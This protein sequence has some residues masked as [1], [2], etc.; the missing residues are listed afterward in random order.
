MVMMSSLEVYEKLRGELNQI[1]REGDNLVE[2]DELWLELISDSME[3]KKVLEIARD[4]KEEGNSLFK[5]GKVD[6][7]LEMYGYAEVILARY[8]FEEEEDRSKFCELALCILLNSTACF[9]RKK[10]FVQ[11]GQVC[12]IILEFQPNNVKAMYR[13]AMA[14]IELERHDM[15]YWDLVLAAEINPKNQEVVKK[16]EEV[17]NFIKAK[18]STDQH[19]NDFPKGLGSALPPPMKK[20]EHN[21]EIEHSSL[22]D[23]YQEKNSTI[24]VGKED[25]GQHIV[26]MS[27]VD[28]KGS[29]E[30]PIKEIEEGPKMN[31]EINP[32]VRMEGRKTETK[33]EEMED[34]LSTSSDDDKISSVCTEDKNESLN[35]AEPMYRFNN[36]RRQGSILS[37][38]RSSY[39]MMTQGKPLKYYNAKLGS[40]MEVRLVSRVKEESIDKGEDCMQQ[41]IC[42]MNVGSQ[43]T[44][45]KEMQ[46]NTDSTESYSEVHSCVT[47]D[48]DDSHVEESSSQARDYPF[49]HFSAKPVLTTRKRY[50][51]RMTTHDTSPPPVKKK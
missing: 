29:L 43:P 32:R 50:E 13:R 11:V 26:N 31:E 20:S 33:E 44:L 10:E 34:K 21:L 46:D 16:L 5:L 39:L 47:D 4:M 9:S 2:G 19:Q 38:S 28:D 25:K 6:N 37:I 40:F 36:R 18:K 23:E 51:A 42:S 49:F 45:K 24:I 15:A 17:K 35:L 22:Q 30:L 12:S 48:E 8:K 27:N 14:A 41:R 3:P 1:F 7:A